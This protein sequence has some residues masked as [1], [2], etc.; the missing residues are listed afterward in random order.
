MAKEY[1]F[2]EGDTFNLSSMWVQGQFSVG[3]RETFGFT[4]SFGKHHTVQAYEVTGAWQ[5]DP[6]PH[7]PN[8]EPTLGP[9][10]KFILWDSKELSTIFLPDE[11]FDAYATPDSLRLRNSGQIKREDGS[12]EMLYATGGGDNT[13][14]A[15]FVSEDKMAGRRAGRVRWEKNHVGFDI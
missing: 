14:N 15:R 13:F 10:Q 8:A 4:D 11:K 3:K 1:R 2:K 9:K 6:P 5:Q 12:T 7:A